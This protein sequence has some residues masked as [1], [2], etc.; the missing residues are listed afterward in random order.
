MKSFR[1]AVLRSVCVI[2]SATV[3]ASV[4][5]AGVPAT[6]S[7]N[8][9]AGELLFGGSGCFVA[10]GLSGGS[11]AGMTTVTGTA[12]MPFV[13]TTF[14]GTGFQIKCTGETSGSDPVDLV[15]TF[16]G[17]YGFTL[18]NTAQTF[19]LGNSYTLKVT[20]TGAPFRS[21]TGQTQMGGNYE[22][23]NTGG[24]PAGYPRLFPTEDSGAATPSVTGTLAKGGFATIPPH[25]APGCDGGWGTTLNTVFADGVTA[26][27]LDYTLA[28]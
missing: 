11:A 27:S 7:I 1:R 4:A 20:E 17:A 8:A 21:C 18:G 23:E 25:F 10:G 3:I 13:S 24:P 15:M 22:L 2:A 12:A 19:Q 16:P 26:L 9:G 14:S 28:Y 5:F 6:F